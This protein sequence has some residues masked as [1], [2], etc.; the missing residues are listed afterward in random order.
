MVSIFTGRESAENGGLSASELAIVPSV[1]LGA[2]SPLTV[3]AS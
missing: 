2:N 1:D 3:S